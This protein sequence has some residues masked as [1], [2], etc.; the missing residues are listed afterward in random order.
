MSKRRT[1]MQQLVVLYIVIEYSRRSIRKRF[2]VKP[3]IK[4]IEL[5]V[6]FNNKTNIE[7][8]AHT[9]IEIKTLQILIVK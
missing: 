2:P 6:H 1:Q 5:L 8:I 4:Y 9:L 3:K 7:T